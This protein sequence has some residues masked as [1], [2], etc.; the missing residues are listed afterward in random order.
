MN[1]S[2]P[3]K[4][5]GRV[6]QE[7]WEGWRNEMFGLAGYLKRCLGW[8]S[9]VFSWRGVELGIFQTGRKW[10]VQGVP[11]QEAWLNACN[12]SLPT[13]ATST[14]TPSASATMTRPPMLH[15]SITLL[16]LSQ[17]A[18]HVSV[19]FSPSIS[20]LF[21]RPP[22]QY[23][24]DKSAAVLP[25]PPPFICIKISRWSVRSGFMCSLLLQG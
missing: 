4:S 5:P 9:K 1:P 2:F 21:T 7:I 18:M 24:T 13:T 25:P 11:R 15:L 10:A 16:L 17:T 12:P 3:L 14:S 23:S 6:W 20:S 8:L 22:V 19:V